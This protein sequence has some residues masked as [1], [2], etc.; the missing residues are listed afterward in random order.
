ML[1]EKFEKEILEKIKSKEPTPRWRFQMK[2]YMIWSLGILSLL[3]GGLASSVLIY[4]LMN[5]GWGTYGRM[6]FGWVEFFLL[7]LPYFWVIILSIFI[8]AAYYYVKHTKNGYRYSIPAIIVFSIVASI[9]LGGCGS[10]LGLGEAID[11]ILGEKA[12]A[13]Y[14]FFNPQIRMWREPENGRLFGLVTKIEQ[15]NF[16]LL[17]ISR[18]EWKVYLEKKPPFPLEIG[19]PI[20]LLGEK[21]HD[22]EFRAFEIL[23]PGPGQG[24]LRNA[25]PP[26]G[27]H[28]ACHQPR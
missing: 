10:L 1:G 15:E 25:C 2:D 11:N 21:L 8:L 26:D 3:V 24:F 20:K 12:P 9:L 13:Y 28:P 19:R 14:E 23:P 6:N 16:Y 5:G 27:R 22:N 4:F 7:S 17:D 18:Q